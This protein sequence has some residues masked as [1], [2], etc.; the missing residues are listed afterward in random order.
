MAVYFLSDGDYCKIGVSRRLKDRI[1]GLQLASPRELELLLWFEPYHLD[2]H[3]YSAL[4]D[5]AIELSIHHRLGMTSE[6]TEMSQ[7][8]K[9]VISE[10]EQCII[11]GDRDMT[12]EKTR[13]LAKCV[14]C[15]KE[16]VSRRKYAKYCSVTCC[17]KAEKKRQQNKLRAKKAERG[18]LRRRKCMACGDRISYSRDKRAIY[19][20][21]KCKKAKKARREMNARG[22]LACGRALPHNAPKNKIYCNGVCAA[23]YRSAHRKTDICITCGEEKK[24]AAREMCA[25]C[26][27]RSKL[28][29]KWCVRCGKPYKNRNPLAMYCSKKCK[30]KAHRSARDLT[31]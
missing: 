4:T 17:N 23:R 14:F 2:T 8:V 22:C 1:R 16:I 19:C 21:D 28:D 31:S 12:D 30:G 29:T 24:I 27:A 26:Y 6:W 20:S 3:P 7:G 25:A 13:R 15:G 9:D 18:E 10:I 5:Y 11:P